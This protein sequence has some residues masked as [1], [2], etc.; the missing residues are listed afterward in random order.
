MNGYNLLSNV[1]DYIGANAFR[2]ILPPKSAQ[3]KSSRI[4]HECRRISQNQEN[5]AE[6]G[7]YSRRITQKNVAEYRTLNSLSPVSAKYSLLAR[8]YTF[9]H[10]SFGKLTRKSQRIM[11]P[12][13]TADQDVPLNHNLRRT[14]HHGGALVLF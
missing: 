5:I 1:A 14:P 12:P 11:C 9:L 4:S 3:G 7:E 13:H 8:A 6:S 2:M 10:D